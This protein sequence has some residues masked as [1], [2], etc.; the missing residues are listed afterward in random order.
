M[1]AVNLLGWRRLPCFAHTLNLIVQDSLKS[2]TEVSS[3]QKKCK[4]VVSFFHCSTNATE[5]LLSLQSQTSPE[6][7]ALKLKQDVERRWNSTFYMMERL[8]N[9][10]EVVTTTLCLLGRHDLCLSN[11]DLDLMKEVVSTLKPFETTTHEMS[12]DSFI[13]VSKIIPLVH[14]L[15]D[16]VKSVNRT[17]AV[18]E[19][20]APAGMLEAELKNQMRRFSQIESN[21]VL[22]ASTILDPHFKKVAFCSLDTSE[23]TIDHISHE[24][25]GLIPAETATQDPLSDSTQN[26]ESATNSDLWGSFDKKVTEASAHRTGLVESAVEVRRYI[27]EKNLPQ[28]EDPLKWWKQ[29][30]VHYPNLS[31]YSTKFL[32]IPATSVPSERLFSKAG[33]LVSK[34]RSSLKPSNINMLLF[35]NK[36]I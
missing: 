14:L 25:G 13:S 3:L 1:A 34:K 7:K 23:R 30:T 17:A 28:H 15:Q 21:F 18:N 10:H 9:P 26:G 20:D 36:N 6:A 33:E 16:K 32:C 31:Q 35:L 29:Q 4:D 11:S 19:F 12:S 27:Q 5:K 24:V 8:V 22:S 2:G